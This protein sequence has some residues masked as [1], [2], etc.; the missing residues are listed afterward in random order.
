[1][2]FGHNKVRQIRTASPLMLI[3]NTSITTYASAMDAF[4]HGADLVSLAG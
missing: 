3:A 2:G 1:M 4:S